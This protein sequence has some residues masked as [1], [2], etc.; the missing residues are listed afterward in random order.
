M[1]CIKACF[2]F[3]EEDILHTKLTPPERDSIDELMQG[4]RIYD[5][6]ILETLDCLSDQPP[7]SCVLE[8]DMLEHESCKELI[9]SAIADSW[10]DL[11]EGISLTSLET[12]R[13]VR[14]KKKFRYEYDSQRKQFRVRANDKHIV[15]VG[16]K[17]YAASIYNYRF[18]GN[19]P[20]EGGGRKLYL[21]YGFPLVRAKF[22]NKNTSE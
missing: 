12:T 5:K 15:F 21:D 8:C 18:K 13:V 17:E 3:N 9:Q 4:M 20:D 2:V 1:N 14:G 6:T 19:L 22:D 16:V 10:D 11:K 7:K